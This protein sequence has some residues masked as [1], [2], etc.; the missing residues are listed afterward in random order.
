MTTRLQSS[1]SRAQPRKHPR[2]FVAIDVETANH[3]PGSVCAIGLATVRDGRLRDA[4]NR[5]DRVHR[6]TFSRSVWPEIHRHPAGANS[7]RSAAMIP[8]VQTSSR[9]SPFSRE[10]SRGDE[11]VPLAGVHSGLTG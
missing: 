11:S 5:P 2:D 8:R 9:I 4:R 10:A 7:L 1:R 3:D 6:D